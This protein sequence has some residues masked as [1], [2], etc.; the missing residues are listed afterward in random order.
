MKPDRILATPVV[1]AS[2]LLF[3]GRALA[4]DD[5]SDV[6]S[7]TSCAQWAPITGDLAEDQCTVAKLDRLRLEREYD[8]FR[9]RTVADMPLPSHGAI[10]DE[11]KAA[12]DKVAR[13][14]SRADLE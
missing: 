1:F 10:L 12:S 7:G 9:K 4:C 8:P 14:C 11:L 6:T 2:A 3:V 5:L 13:N